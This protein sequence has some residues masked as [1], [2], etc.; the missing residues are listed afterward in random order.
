MCT[1]GQAVAQLSLALCLDLYYFI[2]LNE[3]PVRVEGKS[4]AHLP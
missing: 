2:E 1:R 3:Y 4:T